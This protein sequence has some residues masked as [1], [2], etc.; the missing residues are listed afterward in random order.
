MP[1]NVLLIVT[2]DQRSESLNV[3]RAVSS[4]IGDRG[5]RF[6]NAV[7]A[8][9]T[10]GP[11][12]VSLLTGQHAHAHGCYVNPTTA[13][14]FAPTDGR[15]IGA[16]LRGVGYRTGLFGKYL[17]GNR[18]LSDT[19]VPPGWDAWDTIRGQGGYYDYDLQHNDYGGGRVGVVVHYGSATRD[20]FS[21]VITDKASGFIRSTPPSVPVFAYVA[22]NAPHSPYVP[23][24]RHKGSLAAMAP[25]RPP[26][27]DEDDVSD[28]PAWLRDRPKWDA[29]TRAMHD[30]QRVTQLETLLS[31]DEGVSALIQTLQEVGRLADTLIVYTSDNGFLWGEHRLWGKSVPYRP[32]HEIPLQ[33]RWDAR[34][35][36]GLTVPIPVSTT[37]ISAT[38]LAVSGATPS[39]IQDGRSLGPFFRNASAPIGRERVFFEKQTGGG[40]PGFC[41]VRDESH[42][43]V[44]YPGGE[45][46]FYNY[47]KDPH[48]LEDRVEDPASQDTVKMLRNR[49]KNW[50]EP[51]PPGMGSWG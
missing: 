6:R 47:A 33:L 29:A 42:L 49:T 14:D 22:Y 32:A 1:P 34:I 20:Y 7:V 16:W 48:E 24:R 19:Y 45:E 28:K 23:A 44:R 51:L 26:S 38:L 37:D 25:W 3:M 18:A 15:Q 12:R 4:E 31:V 10:C 21:D 8:V 2:D 11:N 5:I 30:G 41:A 50:C 40:V 27:Y 36:P 35:T 39:R 17:N 13:S 46:E 43:Y 9:P